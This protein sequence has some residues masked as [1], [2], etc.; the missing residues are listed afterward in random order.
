M[1]RYGKEDQVKI[2][3]V[4][5]NFAALDDLQ[6]SFGKQ[7]ILEKLYAKNLYQLYSG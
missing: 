6:K 3:V 7:K 5:F 2:C 1:Y 4:E